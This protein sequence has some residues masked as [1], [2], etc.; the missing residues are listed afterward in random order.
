[1]SAPEATPP[2]DVQQ[3]QRLAEAVHTLRAQVG[4]RIVGQQEVVDGILTAIL[5]GVTPC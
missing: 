1:M 4:R 5:A 2:D 3:L